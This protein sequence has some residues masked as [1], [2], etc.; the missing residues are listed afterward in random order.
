MLPKSSKLRR[1]TLLAA[2]ATLSAGAAWPSPG[3]SQTAAR[4]YAVFSE[5]SPDTKPLQGGWNRR[6]FTATDAQGG[7]AIS[8]DPAT[9]IVAVG[10]GAWHMSGFSTVTYNSGSEPPETTTI[11]SPAAAGYCR[12][13]LVGAEP[14]AD[15]LGMHAIDNADKSVLCIGSASNANMVPSLFETFHESDR[16][17][18]LVLEHQAGDRPEQI[19]LRV[20]AQNS[21][22]HAVARL[23]I[24]RL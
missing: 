4:D 6:I 17:V 19:Y 23:A 2:G 21:P 7:S 18:R 20:F 16:P 8:R 1:R 3:Q 12:L 5:L 11:R 22:W 24:R 14:G 10:P 15:P 13:R 9:G